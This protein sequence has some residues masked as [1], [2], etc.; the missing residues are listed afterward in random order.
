VDKQ[1]TPDAS[2]FY[3]LSKDDVLDQ[4]KPSL[5]H[6]DV[7]QAERYLVKAFILHSHAIVLT[8]LHH[9]SACLG[10]HPTRPKHNS[11]AGVLPSLH[12]LDMSSKDQISFIKYPGSDILQP[13]QS[14][15]SHRL[16]QQGQWLD[17]EPHEGHTIVNCGDALSAVRE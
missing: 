7:I 6:L 10:L 14:S 17:V 15:A 11:S 4:L 9:I 8:L 12:R 1:G 13:K 16:R 3:N 5:P 2:E